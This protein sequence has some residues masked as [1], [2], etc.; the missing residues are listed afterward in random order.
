MIKKQSKSNIGVAK[1]AQK[2]SFTT[3]FEV[4]IPQGNR[5]SLGFAPLFQ[6]SI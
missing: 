2:K 4:R 1:R 3:N 5:V 6:P